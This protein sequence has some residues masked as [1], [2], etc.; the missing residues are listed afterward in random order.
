MKTI[1]KVKIIPQFVE[2]IPEN[3][4]LIENN[5][6]ISEKYKACVH[7]C[8][9]GCGNIVS[10]PL[11]NDGWNLIKHSEDLISLIPSIGNYSF[12]CRSHYVISKNIAN[13]I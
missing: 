7:K 1:K 12:Q 11:N 3:N 4:E 13:F 10:T 9:C 5:L 6:Y 2:Y 8:L